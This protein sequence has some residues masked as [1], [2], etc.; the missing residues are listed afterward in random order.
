MLTTMSI[1]VDSARDPTYLAILESQTQLALLES[2]L[3]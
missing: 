3:K 2:H 1:L